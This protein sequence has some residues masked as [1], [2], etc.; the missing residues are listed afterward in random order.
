MNNGDV[1]EKKTTNKK[2]TGNL[3]Q[4]HLDVMGGDWYLG[5]ATNVHDLNAC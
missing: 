5:L 2:I 4:S 3:Q 1:I